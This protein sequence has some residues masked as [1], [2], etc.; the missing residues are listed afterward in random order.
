MACSIADC[1]SAH[2][3]RGMCQK[4]Y[5]VEYR[6]RNRERRRV[7]NAEWRA[8]NPE[9][10]RS[11]DVAYYAAHRE[12]ISARQG[13]YRR[14]NPEKMRAKNALRKARKLGV[15]CE[16]VSYIGILAAYGM[17]C[18]ICAGE[19]A[20]RSDLHFDHVI[21][22]ALG[23]AHANDNIRPS[24]ARCNLSK[25]SRLLAGQTGNTTE[26]IGSS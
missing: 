5:L 20:D 15:R 12:V 21:P 25:G 3:A 26:L 7:N 8:R 13:R 17:V 1:E 9:Y 23:G 19:I 16:R 22:L 4:H 10:H 6:K 18:H 14:T 2:Y 11:Y 24:H